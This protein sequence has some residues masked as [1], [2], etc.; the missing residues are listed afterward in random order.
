MVSGY[1]ST[2]PVG[3]TCGGIS[4][5]LRNTRIWIIKPCEFPANCILEFESVD[6]DEELFFLA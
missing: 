5:R 3:D 6:W 2:W 1:L 4:G